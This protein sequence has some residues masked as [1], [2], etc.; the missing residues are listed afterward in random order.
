MHIYNINN[1]QQAPKFEALKVR[2]LTSAEI[3]QIKVINEAYD[4]IFQKLSKYN[5]PSRLKFKKPFPGLYDKEIGSGLLLH[6]GNNLAKKFHL[7]RFGEKAFVKMDILDNKKNPLLACSFSDDEITIKT[8]DIFDEN[9]KN[10]TEKTVADL[11]K[12]AITEI[13]LLLDYTR[14]FNKIRKNLPQKNTKE[15]IINLIAESQKEIE[16]TL[17]ANSDE[18]KKL[19]ETYKDFNEMGNHAFRRQIWSI[20]F[21]R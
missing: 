15:D 11:F 17:Y 21:K 9:P 1:N 14:A 12:N 6:V 8:S 5:F 18:I 7:H 19:F 13:K 16:P 20:Q 4:E 3:G 2:K 10:N